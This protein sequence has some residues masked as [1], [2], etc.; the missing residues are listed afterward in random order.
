[1]G[2]VRN[3]VRATPE[4]QAANARFQRAFARLRAFNTIYVKRFAKELRAERDKRYG[5]R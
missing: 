5:R 1:M 4:F 3:D 2:G